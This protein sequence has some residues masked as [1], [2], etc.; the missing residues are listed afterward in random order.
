VERDRVQEDLDNSAYTI[1]QAMHFHASEVSPGI[2]CMY[3]LHRLLTTANTQRGGL[4]A[5][6]THLMNGIQDGCTAADHCRQMMQFSLAADRLL[7]EFFS[8]E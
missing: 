8:P 7:G 4:V 6:G 5:S 2:L 1:S 3:F